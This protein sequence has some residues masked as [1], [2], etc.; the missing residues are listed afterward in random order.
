MGI[1][2]IAENGKVHADTS[3]IESDI[4]DMHKDVFGHNFNAE[5]LATQEKLISQTASLIEKVCKEVV[6][7]INK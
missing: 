4:R 3:L 5:E 6:D 7:E 1:F 2:K